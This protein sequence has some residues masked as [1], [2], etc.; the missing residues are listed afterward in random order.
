MPVEVYKVDLIRLGLTDEFE[1]DLSPKKLAKRL[2]KEKI[3]RSFNGKLGV[4]TLEQNA[5]S[6][7]IFLDQNKNCSVYDKRPETCRNHPTI[8]PRSG[9]CAYLKK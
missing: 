8:G 2:I 3:I 6:E 1:Y 7:C 5:F 4:F 9:F